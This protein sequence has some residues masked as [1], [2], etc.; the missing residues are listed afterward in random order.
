MT[1]N[2]AAHHI[3]RHQLALAVT[4]V[5]HK[6]QFRARLFIYLNKAVAV[7]QRICAARF[8]PY[9][10][11]RKHRGNRDLDVRFPRNGN[12]YGVNVRTGKYLPVIG[13]LERARLSRLFYFI[14]GGF[15]SVRKRVANGNYR[16]LSPFR[17]R[18][19]RCGDH[20]AAALTEPDNSEF[21]TF[22]HNFSF[23]LL[24]PERQKR[25]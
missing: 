1:D 2:A 24:D 3:Q 25:S 9:R 18:Q 7:F 20:S 16:N 19:Q 12:K 11:A 14:C 8:K 6:H 21:N 5:L 13:S 15:Y 17:K 10:F 23:A 4:A 22:F